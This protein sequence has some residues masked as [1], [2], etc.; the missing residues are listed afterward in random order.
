MK[1]NRLLMIVPAVL[2]IL[3]GCHLSIERD[4]HVESGRTVRGS[5]NVIEGDITIGSGCLIR[6][7]CR[8]VD[9]NIEVGRDSQVDNL[10]SVDG[11]IYVGREVVVRRDVELVDGDIVCRSGVVVGGNINAIDGSIEIERTT[12]RR[13]I[14][15][16]D[17][18]IRLRDRSRVEGDIIIK[19][20]PDDHDRFRRVTIE[21]S[22]GSV[23][24]GDIVN[25]DENVDVRVYLEEGGRIEGRVSEVEVIRR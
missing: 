10:Q 16:Y 8:T 12:V 17:A 18:D 1:P 24:E 22:G 11:N 25:R 21:I 19:R 2:L 6:S 20:S 13:D 23:V 7:S 5:I 14:T 3:A 9:G 15:T 4:I